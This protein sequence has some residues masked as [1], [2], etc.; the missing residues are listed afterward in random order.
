MQESCMRN[1]CLCC[2]VKSI[3]GLVKILETLKSRY[4]IGIPGVN[5]AEKLQLVEATRQHLDKGETWTKR[6]YRNSSSQQY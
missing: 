2:S 1:G 3:N 4:W 6:S 5:L